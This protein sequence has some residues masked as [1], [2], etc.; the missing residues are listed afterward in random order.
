MFYTSF[1]GALIDVG[2][3]WQTAHTL[4]QGQRWAI[5]D[6]PSEQDLKTSKLNKIP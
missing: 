6:N 2:V 3:G 1:N 5:D 4:T